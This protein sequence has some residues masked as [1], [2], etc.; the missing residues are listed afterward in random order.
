MG[1]R[2][3]DNSV[4]LADVVFLN[5]IQVTVLNIVEQKASLSFDQGV[6][7]FNNQ[8]EE[9]LIINFPSQIDAS[10]VA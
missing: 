7:L 1:K 6:L 3:L 9:K 10:R 5:R 2:S 8:M 4:A